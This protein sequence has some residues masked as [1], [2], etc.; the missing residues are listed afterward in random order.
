[1]TD[2][3]KLTRILVIIVMF[4][5]VASFIS[6]FV[7]YPKAGTAEVT[8]NTL[9]RGADRLT[10]AAVKKSSEEEWTRDRL[11]SDVKD[12]ASNL[13]AAIEIPF[14]SNKTHI[15]RGI[16][17]YFPASGAQ[18]EKE[19][20]GLLLSIAH[21]RTLQPPSIKTD[22][23]V[24]TPPKGYK[25]AKSIGCTEDK[26]TSFDDPER[27][28]IVEHIPLYQRVGVKDPLVGYKRFLDSVL[29]VA[30][31]RDYNTYDYLM[32][33]DMDTFVAPAFADWRLPK[34]KIIATGKGEYGNPTA[35]V[36]LSYIMKTTFH[37]RDGG[38]KNIGTTWY[39]SPA[40]LVAASQLSVASM[41]WLDRMEFTEYQRVR[42]A[43][44]GYYWYWPVLTMY[45]GQIAINQIPP[46]KVQFDEI[47]VMEMDAKTNAVG[48]FRPSVRHLHC[49]YVKDLFSKTAFAKG[50]YDKLDLNEHDHM[51]TA[52]AYSAVIALSAVRMSTEEFKLITTDPERMRKFEWKRLV[53]SAKSN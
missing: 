51:R 8:C 14:D 11:M 19:L 1:M 16:A 29:M 53:P 45:G 36:R 4:G 34:G 15:S 38:H 28:V 25:F 5:V 47:K 52:P 35:D 7:W 21:V 33:T 3:A 44:A 24:F 30:E 27:C 2:N 32:K 23:I 17:I 49:W 42:S 10:D 13:S 31:Y 46:D 22:L 43:D 40:V 26:R 20:K 18:Q 9:I 50:T 37:M 41:R 6:H 39:G 48:E 12:A